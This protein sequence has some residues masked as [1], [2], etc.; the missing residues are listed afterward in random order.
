MHPHPCLV[1]PLDDGARHLEQTPGL[2]HLERFVY[3]SNTAHSISA[4]SISLG[5]ELQHAPSDSITQYFFLQM[6]VTSLCT[7]I[8]YLTIDQIPSSAEDLDKLVCHS[9]AKHG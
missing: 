2:L 4:H 5:I 1:L 9:K 8:Y 7:A 6:V 3:R